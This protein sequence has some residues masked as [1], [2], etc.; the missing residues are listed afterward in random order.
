[1]KSNETLQTEVLQ[2]LKWEPLLN[3]AHIGVSARDGIITLT[4]I[5]DS[6]SKKYHA[7][8]AAKNVAGVKAVVEKI[9]V[10]FGTWGIKDDNEIAKEIVNSF[11]WNWEI[12]ESKIKIKVEDAWVTLEGELPWNYQREAARKC[13]NNIV[14]VKGISNNLTIKADSDEVVEKEDIENA[15]ARNW[16]INSKDV[17]VKVK[18]NTVTLTGIVNSW[19]QRDEA[20]RIAWNAPGIY[21]VHNELEVHYDYEMAD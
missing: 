18:G 7:E 12:P 14:G 9:E 13:V 21:N 5:V 15:L 19:Y 16:S 3:V 1:M 8:N 20:A 2:A 11:K 10:K 4:G 17:H 6:Y